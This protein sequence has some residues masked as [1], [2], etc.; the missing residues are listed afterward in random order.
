M[1]K[2]TFLSFVKK[3]ILYN[4]ATNMDATCRTLTI[5]HILM[6]KCGCQEHLSLRMKLFCKF[7]GTGKYIR[8][9]NLI[10]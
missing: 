2:R 10:L 8:L 9:E 6:Y 7:Y 1:L 3:S 5:L 4:T